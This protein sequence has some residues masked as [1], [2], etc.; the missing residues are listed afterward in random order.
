M[1]S[2]K[3]RQAKR[4]AKLRNDNEA[5]KAYLEKDR[6]RKATQ[7]SAAKET[8]RNAEVEEHHL[9]ERLRIIQYREREKLL[10]QQRETDQ[11]QTSTPYRTNQAEGKAITRAQSSLSVPPCKRCCVVETLAKSVGISIKSAP[12]ASSSTLISEELKKLILAFY[13]CND[14]SWQTPG[15]K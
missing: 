13:S 4:R 12:S 9:K 1:A 15:R 8:M 2:N 6:Q 11:P 14:I 7:R 5:Y 3:E 10:N